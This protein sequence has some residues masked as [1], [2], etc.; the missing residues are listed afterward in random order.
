MGK[1]SNENGV[2]GVRPWAHTLLVTTREELQLT[3]LVH[4]PDGSLKYASGNYTALLG[5]HGIAIS[6]SDKATPNEN[7]KAEPFMKTQAE[8]T[9]GS[10]DDGSTSADLLDQI[11]VPIL[12]FTADAAYDHRSI[13]E[14]VGA[15]GTE[16]VVI[17]IPPRRSVVSAGPTD[18]PWAQR[19]AALDRARAAGRRQW[20]KESGYRQQAW[21]EN[22]FFRYKSV[23]GGGPKARNRDA[24]KREALTACHILNRMAELG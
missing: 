19:E 9:A 7:V 21:V 17:V 2:N 10:G 18:G 3:G 6:M 23:L 14:R 8:L 13:Y 5:E 15:A 20:Q 4:H 1:H 12:R 11:E 22:G 24:Q 16:D